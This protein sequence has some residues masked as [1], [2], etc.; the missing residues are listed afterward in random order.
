MEGG[1]ALDGHAD[2]DLPPGDDLEFPQPNINED[3]PGD[4]LLCEEPADGAPIPGEEAA[5]RACQASHEAW[6]Q[7]VEESKDVMVKNLTFVEVLH[8]RAVARVYA[9]LRSLGLPVYRIHCDRARELI[10]A[11]VRRW[12]LNRGI[13]VSYTHL[14]LPTKLEV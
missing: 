6:H 11:P 13:A 1:D 4:A 3:D 10:S 7:M 14:T 12:S 2:H 9:R 8:G 5:L